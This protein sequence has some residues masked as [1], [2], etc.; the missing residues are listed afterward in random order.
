[1]SDTISVNKCPDRMCEKCD[2]YKQ[3]LN[4]ALDMIEKLNNQLN[5][6]HKSRIS[7]STIPESVISFISNIEL[8]EIIGHTSASIY[9]KYIKYCYKNDLKKKQ[10]MLLVKLFAI[11]LEL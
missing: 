9:E 4:K 10:N 3:E 8:K 11:V 1:M 2:Y 7:K 6:K 5:E